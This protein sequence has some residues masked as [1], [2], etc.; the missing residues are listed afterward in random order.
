MAQLARSRSAPLSFL[1]LA[2]MALFVLPATVGRAAVGGGT[3]ISTAQ[4]GA[5]LDPATWVGGLLPSG[6]DFAVI[7]HQVELAA[8]AVVVQG[9]VVGGSQTGRLD[10]LAGGSLTSQQLTVGAGAFGSLVVD[11]GSVQTSNLGV[12]VSPGASGQAAFSAGSVVCDTLVVGGV[13]SPLASV[14]VEG[15]DVI[16]FADTGLF[17][18]A[19]GNLWLKPDALGVEGFQPLVA[20]NVTFDPGSRL[21]TSFSEVD[22][23]LGHA[24]D[25]VEFN[26]LLNGLPTTVEVTGFGYEVAVSQTTTGLQMVVT[27]VPPF[28]DIGGGSEVGA[29]VVL[30]GQGALTPG[31]PLTI[32]IAGAQPPLALAWLSLS[33]VPFPALGGTVHAF[34]YTN[35]FLLNTSAGDVVLPTTWPGSIPPGISFWLQVV[36]QDLAVPG[37]LV[38][39]NALRGTAH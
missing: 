3:S 35:Q 29:P 11:G 24:W 13:S 7:D 19:T 1:F 5:W 27:D 25:I 12:A 4:D 2:L 31:S 36:A 18:G 38:L 6:A 10:V 16:V 34:P 28:V 39:S 14:V 15:G 26:G 22:P 21:T 33:P 32:T 30:T 23:L 20:G 17:V 37:G 9:V 8:S